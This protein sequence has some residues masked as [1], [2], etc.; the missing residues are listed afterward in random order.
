MAAMGFTFVQL[1]IHVAMIVIL[2]AVALPRFLAARGAA[3]AGSAIVKD[4]AL[5]K[6]C[7]TYFAT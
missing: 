4:V 2:S 3:G 7:A 1:M 6:G 5:A